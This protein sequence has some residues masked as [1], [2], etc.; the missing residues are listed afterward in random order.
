MFDSLQGS[1]GAP[2]FELF[3][4]RG[5]LRG[6]PNSANAQ[7]VGAVVAA[8]SA[9]E[10]E[11][12]ADPVPSVRFSSQG[13]L[14]L[15]CDDERQIA[16]AL[17]LSK[18][19]A[20][21]VLIKDPS[22]VV[23]P[24]DRKLGML[25]VEVVGLNGF[26]GAFTASVRKTNPIDMELCTRC[27][28]CADV[29]PSHSI[30]LQSLTIN[31]DT[32]DRSG[33]CVAAC[34]DFKAI[35]FADLSE[36]ST[37]EYDM[38]IDC[39]VTGLLSDRQSPLGYW[40]VGHSEAMLLEAMLDA[41]QTVGEFEKPKFFDYKASVCSH[42][43]SQKNGCNACVE[44]CSTKA[45]E[46]AGDKI[47]VNPHLC[48]G[49]GACTSVCPTGALQFAL[50]PATSQG[51]AIRA[52]ARAFKT[53]GGQKLEL[54]F[55]ADHCAPNWLE[56]AKASAAKNH[57]N[58]NDFSLLP[59]ALH[60]SASAGPDLWLSALAYGVDRITVVQDSE[61]ARHYGAALTE[62]AAW[63]NQVLLGLGLKGERIRVLSLA[64]AEH[65]FE[66]SDMASS[67]IE[68]A[69]FE[70]SNSKR[71]RMEFALDHLAE[72]LRFDTSTSIPLAKG[73][74]FGAVVVNKESCTL[75]MSC[76]SACPSSALV[77][78]PLEPQLRFIERNC[79]QCGLCVETCPE[80][81]IG[82]LPQLTLGPVAREKQVLN[83]SQPFHCISCGKAFG[84][85]HMIES[86]LSRMSGHSMFAQN[87]NRLKMC[88]D[89]RVSDM[90][91]AKDEMT[92]MDVKR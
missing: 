50:T 68:P 28:A 81:A 27:G 79:V 57:S 20:V 37:R 32:C 82:L 40:H 48:L 13:R 30:A 7:A 63:V 56:T 38:V 6:Q 3:N 87:A 33:A 53:N 67:G 78:N 46:S 62:Q 83:Q 10:T 65:V 15:I 54:V 69:S 60:H 47:A 66:A 5:A 9:Y 23:L 76:T 14:A 18:T 39:T 92:I 89:C 70:M 44:V 41:L 71:T 58:A 2:E 42:S 52:A 24:P 72:Q 88:G 49:C 16:Q 17:V 36:L 90:F 19:L 80:N 74:P 45:I 51:R 29:C 22:G 77:D 11:F 43:R 55:H 86:M 34:G 73:A 4:L 85:K 35:S 64:N 84:T 21:D 59:I 26:L 12:E 61:E 91:S 31:N 8:R 25:A 1:G 75:C